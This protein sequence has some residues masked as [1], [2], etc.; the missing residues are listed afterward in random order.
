MFILN[1]NY[2]VQTSNL[3]E[4]KHGIKNINTKNA[5]KSEQ[6]VYVKFIKII[7][8]ASFEKVIWHFSIVLV[9]F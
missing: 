1:K 2:R 8:L 7:N 3:W 4:G 9:L 5:L 6:I